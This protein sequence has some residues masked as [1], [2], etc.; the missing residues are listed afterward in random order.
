MTGS[1]STKSR[2]RGD[3]RVDEGDLV[4]E[5]DLVDEDDAASRSMA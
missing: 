4:D 5:E 1:L 3:V 2:E